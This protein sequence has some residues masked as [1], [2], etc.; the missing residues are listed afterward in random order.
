MAHA[1]LRFLFVPVSGPGGA[2]EYHRS[3]AVARALERRWPGC[4]IRFVLHRSAPYAADAPYAG[5]LVDDSPTRASAAVIE[6]IRAERPDVVVFDSSGR[7]GQYRAARDVGAAVVYVSSRARTRWKG[8]RWRRMRVLDQHWI[9]QPRFLGGTPTAYERLK[10]R[11]VGRPEIVVLDAVHDPLDVPATRRLQAQL[12][13]EPGRYVALCPGGGGDFGHAVDAAQVFYE[14]AQRLARSSGLAVVAVLGPRVP[15]RSATAPHEAGLRTLATLPN[16]Q[17][18]ALLRDA[19][20]VV[21]NGGSLL[22]QSMAQG[23][24]IVA[25]PVAGDQPERIRRCAR[26]GYVR[27][28]SLDPESMTA[29]VLALL[30]D[31]QARDG[32]RARLAAL[33]LRNGV[34][35]ASDAVM[36]LVQARVRSARGVDA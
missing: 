3:L 6:C 35:E 30:S 21:V 33:A 8:F 24:P 26:E 27:Q 16:G 29:A 10:L 22:L 1:S 19:T 28:S 7:L 17:L 4:Q 9:A 2:G 18:I 34:D 20:V 36:R 31:Q 13:L 11:L 14:V 32:L 15:P 12:G 23:A 5:L 25:A